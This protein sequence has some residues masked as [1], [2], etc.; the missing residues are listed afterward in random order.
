MPDAAYYRAWRRAHPAYRQRQLELHQAR[1]A[2]MSAQE[3]RL[4]RGVGRPAPSRCSEP[5]LGH[6]QHG[7]SISFWEDELRM[8]LH[9]EAALAVLEGRDPVAA[10]RR[11]RYVEREWFRLTFS[12]I[13]EVTDREDRA[14][15]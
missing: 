3:R 4:D 9:Q 11:Y 15:P 5:L 12:F 14:A 7:Q 8:D 10:C 6:L 2:A 13:E 1:R